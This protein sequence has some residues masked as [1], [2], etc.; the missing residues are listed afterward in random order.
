MRTSSVHHPC[1]RAVNTDPTVN[2][3]GTHTDGTAPAGHRDGWIRNA[4]LWELRECPIGHWIPSGGRT[5]DRV[6]GAA[7]RGPWKDTDMSASAPELDPD[8]DELVRGTMMCLLG[9]VALWVEG[10]KVALGGPVQRAVLVTLLLEADRPVEVEHLI[11]TV[12]GPEPTAKA[13]RSLATLLSRLRRELEPLGCSIDHG[14]GTY[15]LRRPPPTDVRSFLSGTA[16][17]RTLIGAGSPAA[18]VEALGDALSLWRGVP[19]GDIDVPGIDERRTA[20][21]EQRW[22]AEDQRVELLLSLDRPD[23]VLVALDAMTAETPYSEH[24]W[25]LL[26]DALNAAGRRRDA[27]IAFGRADRLLREDLGIDPG[28]ELRAA[29]MRALEG[30]TTTDRAGPVRPGGMGGDSTAGPLPG[31]RDE[32]LR[33]AE[34]LNR[35]RGRPSV[36]F[37]VG[38]PGIGK[39]TVLHR[40][41]AAARGRQRVVVGHCPR[42]SASVTGTLLSPI[43]REL[44]DGRRGDPLD[45]LGTAGADLARLVTPGAGFDPVRFGLIEPR[46]VS[47]ASAAID[48]LLDDGPVLIA[49][50]DVQWADRVTRRILEELPGRFRDRP[51][52]LVMCARYLGGDDGGDAWVDRQLGSED[53]EVIRLGPLDDADM[54]HALEH[55]GVPTAGSSEI[56]AAAGGIPL[57]AV[58][59][60]GLLRQRGDTIGSDLP[61]HL[62]RILELRFEHLD[63]ADRRLVRLAAL[64]GS[65]ARAD[66]CISALGVDP[67]VGAEIVDRLVSAGAVHVVDGNGIGFSHELI[68]SY[69]RDRLGPQAERAGRLALLR[70]HLGAGDAAAAARHLDHVADELDVTERVVIRVAA[71]RA[72]LDDGSAEDAERWARA[73]LADRD[74]LP[75]DAG[76]DLVQLD[77]DLGRTLVSVGAFAEARPLLFRAA[78]AARDHQRWDVVGDAL[79]GI[80]RVGQPHEGSDRQLYEALI[81]DALPGLEGDPVR[82][83][84]MA[85][86]AFHLHSLQEPRRAAGYLDQLSELAAREPTLASVLE[87]CRFRQQVEHGP[88]VASAVRSAG[89]LEQRLREEGDELAGLIIALLSLEARQRAGHPID[90]AVR[91]EVGVRARHLGRPDIAVVTDLLAS[92][93]AV[94]S[95]PALVADELV[96]RT[97]AIAMTMGDPAVLL[98]GVAHMFSLRHEQCRSDELINVFDAMNQATPHPSLD[99]LIGCGHTDR[100]D[101]TAAVATLE[102]TWAGIAALDDSD[103]TIAPLAGLTLDLGSKLDV[104][105]AADMRERLRMALLAHSGSM[106]VFAGVVMHLGPTD[107]H[108]GRLDLLEGDAD[109]A[110]RRFRA[111]RALAKRSGLELWTRWCE[112]DLATALCLTGEPAAADEAAALRAGVVR[113]ARRNGWTRLEQAA[114]TGR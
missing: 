44:R 24:R 109:A 72:A 55:M 59:L 105:V 39:S 112:F 8:G 21:V 26:V 111:A 83:G 73:A 20:L 61:D 27:L 22:A 17:A 18:A 65:T 114:R 2:A 32:L 81:T 4:D 9:P 49:V 90:D 85:S 110:M 46:I 86:I 53:V 51:L 15:V 52:S 102:R 68:R 80:G 31:R 30:D 101:R 56:V 71:A 28:P 48:R 113:A 93:I 1:Q 7:L 79:E 100:G 25:A 58:E 36:T 82:Q 98:A 67:I 14:D 50:D 87:V 38:E 103:W 95:R 5:H 45:E 89:R 91:R 99:C 92:L 37:I 88:D 35:T 76:P 107:R 84:R 12:W 10:R 75:G 42:G 13:H 6:E 34:A 33:L 77:L 97:N 43:V 40:V 57:I 69:F 47:A 60:A 96:T 54:R 3:E 64:E 66:R 106:L 104:S 23:R 62:R 41:V 70:S 16:R 108:L 78:S 63:D 11:R 94:W 19:F 29:E 74:A